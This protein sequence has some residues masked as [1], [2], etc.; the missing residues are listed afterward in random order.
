MKVYHIIIVSAVLIMASCTQQKPQL[1]RQ[2]LI[3]QAQGTYFRIVYYDTTMTI[4]NVEVDSLLD[5]FN[6]SASTY[7]K[8]S[9]ISRVNANEA[10]E[11]DKDFLAIFNRSQEISAETDGSFDITVFPLVKAWGFHFEDRQKLNLAQVDSVLEFVGFK[12]VRF[13]GEKIVKDDPRLMIGFNAIAQGYSVDL[14]SDYFLSKGIQNFLI[15]VGGEM[16]ARGMKPENESWQVGIQK[17]EETQY[18][19]DKLQ[20]IVSL[21]NKA[22]ATS[23]NYRKFFVEDGIKYSHTLDPKTGYPVQHSLLSVTVITDDACSADAYATAFMVMGFEK[24]MAF[25]DQKQGLEAYFIFSNEKGEFMV[26]FTDGFKDLIA[27]GE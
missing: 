25:A 24:A 10:T 9:V 11:L 21:T 18:M 8:N 3:G 26:E 19:T 5:A 12:K 4:S 13:D 7:Q 23:G 6:Y 2:E 15:D 1:Q 27:K 14:L 16:I 17:P 20:D 22:L